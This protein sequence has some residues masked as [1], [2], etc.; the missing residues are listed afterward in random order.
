MGRGDDLI[1]RVQKVDIFAVI[2]PDA[3]ISRGSRIQMILCEDPDA[4]I[5]CGAVQKN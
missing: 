5:V 4:G 1:I 3:G 2:S